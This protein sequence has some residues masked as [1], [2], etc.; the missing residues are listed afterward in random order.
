M[1]ESWREEKYEAGPWLRMF[2]NA[3]EFCDE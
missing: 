2:Q 1:P 3:R